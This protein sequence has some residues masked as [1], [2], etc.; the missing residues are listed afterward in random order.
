MYRLVQDGLRKQPD[1]AECLISLLTI[2]RN[3]ERIA[4]QITNI[5]EDIIYLAEGHLVRHGGLL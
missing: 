5:S 3:L 2:S 4:D 1:L